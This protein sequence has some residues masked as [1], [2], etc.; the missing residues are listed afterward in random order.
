MTAV[1]IVSGWIAWVVVVGIW[2]WGMGSFINWSA[3]MRAHG[4]DLY[5]P[6]TGHLVIRSEG[7]LFLFWNQPQIYLQ[8]CMNCCSD[9]LISL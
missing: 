4:S 2:L 8:S 3:S 9:E 1:E 5:L 6:K 7:C